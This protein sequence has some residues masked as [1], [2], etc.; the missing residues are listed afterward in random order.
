MTAADITKVAMILIRNYI[1]DNKLTDKIRLV[2]QVHDQVTTTCLE[3]VADWWKTKLDELMCQAA[4][5]IIPNGLLTA[6][7]NVTDKWSK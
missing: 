2:A 3:E 4:K 1:H 5:F 6:D 7:T